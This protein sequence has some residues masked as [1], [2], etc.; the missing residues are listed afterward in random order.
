MKRISTIKCN[1][2]EIGS[3]IQHNAVVEVNTIEQLLRKAE[4]QA[5]ALN[6]SIKDLK[7]I[8]DS[9]KS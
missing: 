6:N 1:L 3:T 2:H 9:K 5:R 7:K 8:V 4:V